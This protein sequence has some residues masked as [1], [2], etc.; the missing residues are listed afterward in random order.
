MLDTRG[1]R[2]YNTIQYTFYVLR[3][4]YYL[5]VNH[6]KARPP[7]CCV[8]QALSST[9]HRSV[10]YKNWGTKAFVSLTDYELKVSEGGAPLCQTTR[11]CPPSLLLYITRDCALPP[12]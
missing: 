7:L 8:S 12:F 11:D 3:C 1:V 4:V 9:M 6:S 5:Y 2:E 10:D